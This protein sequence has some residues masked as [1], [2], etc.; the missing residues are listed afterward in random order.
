VNRRGNP[1]SDVNVEVWPKSGNF[2]KVWPK[3]RNWWPKKTIGSGKQAKISKQTLP[4]SYALQCSLNAAYYISSKLIA[5]GT[6]D[7]RHHQ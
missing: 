1:P 4:N 2:G 7:G 3:C 5:P 6:I